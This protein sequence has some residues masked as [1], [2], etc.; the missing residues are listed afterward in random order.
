MTLYELINSA[1]RLFIIGLEVHWAMHGTRAKI[2]DWKWFMCRTL[3]HCCRVFL[4]PLEPLHVQSCTFR[5]YFSFQHSNA[6]Y[7]G[8]PELSTDSSVGELGCPPSCRGQRSQ[9]GFSRDMAEN[10]PEVFCEDNKP[11]LCGPHPPL[12]T[13]LVLMSTHTEAFPVSPALQP[14]LLLPC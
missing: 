5:N 12:F 13:A 7:R 4:V 3:L 6:N 8:T 10:P 1:A 2:N 14:V 9:P 11:F